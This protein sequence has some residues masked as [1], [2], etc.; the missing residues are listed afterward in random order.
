M[1]RAPTVPELLGRR[2]QVDFA[3]ARP[4]VAPLAWIL[5]AVG[6][7]TLAA[8]LAGF[9]P[10]WIEHERLAR[11]RSQLQARL[12]RVPGVARPSARAPDAIGLVQARG[13]LDQLDRPWP[14]LLDQFESIDAPDVHLVQFVVDARF[15]TVQ[16]LAEAAQLE[17]VLRYSKQLAGRGPVRS[18]RLTHHEWRAAPG[19]RIVVADLS[20]NL[21]P[22]SS[23]GKGPR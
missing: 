18:V 8:A 22:D 6:T 20:A 2:F 9:A 14:A 19:G 16:L 13:V 17:Q 15:Q 23:A 1:R 11:E 21:G 4:P 10:R 5:L 7:I 3:Q 12:D